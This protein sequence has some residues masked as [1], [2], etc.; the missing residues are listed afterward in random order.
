M[1]TMWAFSADLV[2][3]SPENFTK[4]VVEG[5]YLRHVQTDWMEQFAWN[6]SN[7]PEDL[8]GLPSFP[9]V[10]QVLYFGG[11]AGV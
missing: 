7:P 2:K 6:L 8:S 1:G 11:R 9:V 10:F 5:A 4:T 3:C